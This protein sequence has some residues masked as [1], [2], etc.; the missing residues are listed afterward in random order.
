MIA[1]VAPR[2]GGPSKACLEMA[3][4]VARL[5]HE[6]TVYT[7]NQDGDG[8]LDVP[9][10]RPAFWEGIEI[11][12]HPVQ[13]PRF[14]VTSFPLARALGRALK[15]QRHDLVH[16]HSLYVFHCMVSGHLCRKYGVP[17]IVRPHG[18]LDPFLHR[19]HRLR[20][21]FAELLFESR[22][23]RNATA[24]HFASEEERR[25]AQPYGFGRPAFV[26]PLGIELPEYGQVAEDGFFGR[27]Y[28]E[29]QGKTIVLFLGRI[30][31]K[32]GLDLLVRAFSRLAGMRAD[33]HLVLA[34]PDNEGFGETVRSWLIEEGVVDRC[35]FTGMI[36]GPDKL[37]AFRDA[38]VFVLPSYSENFGISVIEALACGV[39]VVI[40]DN[41]NIWR[42][43]EEGKAAKVVSCDVNSVFEGLVDVLQDGEAAERMGNAGKILVRERFDWPVVATV[44]ERAYVSVLRGG[45]ANSALM[46]V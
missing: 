9:I 12:Y 43:L 13:W 27:V 8:T 39:P 17:Y 24:F 31:F 15:A 14:W 38:A 29:T 16:V 25:L 30:N 32:K 35:T 37:A 28:P 40:S 3:R 45:K 19:R 44:L 4:A 41:V 1:N 36:E 23:M 22:N 2:Y 11:Q 18:T 33:V 10:D 42:E 46:G 20:K 7:T 34:G 26:A 21:T 5:G 6:V